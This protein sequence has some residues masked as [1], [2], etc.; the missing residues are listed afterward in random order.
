MIGGG[1]ED[2]EIAALAP[3]LAFGREVAALAAAG[4]HAAGRFRRLERR[5]IAHDVFAQRR[6]PVGIA[7][8]QRLRLQRLVGRPLDGIFVVLGMAELF[9]GLVIIPDQFQPRRLGFFRLMAQQHQTARQII[10]QRVEMVVEQRQPMLHALGLAPGAD[11]FIKRIVARRAEGRDIAGAKAADRRRIE[12]RFAG[13]Q[14]RNVRHRRLFGKLGFGV[15]AAD[16]VQGRA[17]E[18]QPQRL[19]LS[20]FSRNGAATNP[21]CRRAGRSRPARA[22]CRRA[23][24]HCPPGRRPAL[25][26]PPRRHSWRRSWHS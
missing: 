6:L 25:R 16:G 7:E 10:E 17:E 23:H 22:P 2:I 21:Q 12:R 11:A 3:L 20:P 18:V 8:I 5:K 26:G 19:F 24:S 15:E 9:A 1:L 14:Q 4:I 13:G